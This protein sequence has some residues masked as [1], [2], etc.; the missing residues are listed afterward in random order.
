MLGKV[1]N[2]QMMSDCCTAGSPL[3]TLVENRGEALNVDESVARRKMLW[4]LRR[5][6]R[7]ADGGFEREQAK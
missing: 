2:W 3:A 7:W 1:T 6:S 5:N 4:N